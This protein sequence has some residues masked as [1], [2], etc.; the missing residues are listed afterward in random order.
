MFERMDAFWQSY[1]N[2][3]R[4]PIQQIAFVGANLAI[5]FLSLAAIYV[6]FFVDGKINTTYL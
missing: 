5:G 4:E 3:Y 2:K 1:N 6:A